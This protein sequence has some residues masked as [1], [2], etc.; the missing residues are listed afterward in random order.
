M[1]ADDYEDLVARIEEIYAGF[2]LALPPAAEPWDPPHHPD[3]P[4]TIRV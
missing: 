2:Q 4:H 1:G 3:H